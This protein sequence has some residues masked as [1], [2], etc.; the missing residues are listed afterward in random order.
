MFT[1]GR[2]H[3]CVC[4]S[5]LLVFVKYITVSNSERILN[6]AAILTNPQGHLDCCCYWLAQE[7]EKAMEGEVGNYNQWH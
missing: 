7:R 3:I 1:K 4:K 6:F 5:S 2:H